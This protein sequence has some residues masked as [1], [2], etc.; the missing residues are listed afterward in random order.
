MFI[1]IGNGNIIRTHTI[2]TIIDES[3]ITSSAIMEKLIEEETVV[4]SRNDAKSVVI[5]EQFIYFS[6]LSVTTLKKRASMISTLN[7]L[8]DYS[9]QIEQDELTKKCRWENANG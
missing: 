1:H 3:V 2:I 6:T 9:N 7:R 5:T 4:G 8:D